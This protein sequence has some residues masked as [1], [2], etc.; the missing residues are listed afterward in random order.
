MLTDS[1][2]HEFEQDPVW[3]AGLCFTKFM[4][5]IL[6]QFLEAKKT[7]QR[8]SLLGESPCLIG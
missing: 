7:F 2:G 1:V 5:L 4:A 8:K 6:P 3:T